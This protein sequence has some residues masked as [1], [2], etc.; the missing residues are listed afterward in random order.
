MGNEH[1]SLSASK[2]KHRDY[3][4]H[5]TNTVPRD[6]PSCSHSSSPKAPSSVSTERERGKRSSLVNFLHFVH[7]RTPPP[8]AQRQCSVPARQASSHLA[9]L[10]ELASHSSAQLELRVVRPQKAPI[11]GKLKRLGSTTTPAQSNEHTLTVTVTWRSRSIWFPEQRIATPHA[12]TG[13]TKMKVVSWFWF[14]AP[15]GWMAG[16]LV[17]CSLCRS[18]FP[19]STKRISPRHLRPLL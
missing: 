19:P 16:W 3:Q 18:L 10:G 1:I 12:A 4:Q 15:F 11:R 8:H 14:R 2:I 5:N 13:R 17:I 6:R 9:L 7:P